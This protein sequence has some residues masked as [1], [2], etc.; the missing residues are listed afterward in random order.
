MYLRYFFYWAI[1]YFNKC[2]C[3]C[4]YV[5]MYVCMY[6]LCDKVL[7]NMLVIGIVISIYVVRFTIQSDVG[8]TDAQYVASA[9]NALQIQIMN[10]IYSFLANALTNY[11]NHRCLLDVY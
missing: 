10:Y 8:N 6:L 4:V 11:E 1:L 2:L 5:C 9:L 3:V 7:M